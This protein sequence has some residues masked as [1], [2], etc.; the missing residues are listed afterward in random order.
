LGIAQAKRDT[1]MDGRNFDDLTRRLAKGTNRRSLLKGLIGGGAAMVAAKGGSALAQPSKEDVCHYDDETG[2]FSRLNVSSS[3]VSGHLG[4]GDFLP[5][6]CCV[7]AD[8]LEGYYCD[9]EVDNTATV[10]TCVVEA[11][12]P[13]NGVCDPDDGEICCLVNAN[14]EE[15]ECKIGSGEPCRNNQSCCS[16]ICEDTGLC[17]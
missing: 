11:S 2:E 14:D 16:G 15:Y 10:G 1:V 9:Q 5:R 6:P 12:D 7:N 8:C 4:H 3:A 17:Q 13:C